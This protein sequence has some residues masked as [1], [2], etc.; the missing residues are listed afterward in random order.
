MMRDIET[1]TRDF[2]R[3]Q[4]LIED[5]DAV[6]VALSGGADSVCLLRV[7]LALRE[8]L[9]LSVFATHYNHRLRGADSLRDEQF[10]RDLC[11]RLGVPLRVSSGDVAGEAVHRRRSVEET[12]REMRYAFLEEAA[13]VMGANKIATGH[14]A[15]DNAETVLLH[16]TR[17]AGLR[18]LAGIPPKRECIV[19]PLLPI[20]RQ[21]ILGYLSD[22]EQDFVEDHTNADTAIRRNGIRYRVMPVLRECN[23]NLMQTILRQSEILRRDALFLDRLA[24]DAFAELQGY[25]RGRTPG[26]PASQFC[27]DLQQCGEN[28]NCGTPRCVSPTWGDDQSS[29]GAHCAPLQGYSVNAG[30]HNVRPRVITESPLD[31]SLSTKALLTLDL[32]ISSRVVVLAIQA[33]GGEAAEVHVEQVLE[34][35]QNPNP[36]ARADLP[37][38]QVRREYDRLVFVSEM[39]V[40][41]SFA[42]QVLPLPGTVLIPEAGLRIKVLSK[43]EEIEGKVPTFLFQSASVC[44]KI[45][46]RSRQVGDS[47]RL[48][49]SNGTKTVKKLM[50]ER[51]I[52]AHLRDTLPVFADDLGVIAVFGI[53]IS[54]RVTPKTGEETLGIFVEE[55]EDDA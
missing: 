47:I 22:L 26:R 13:R 53:G 10:V 19:R 52:P 11:E 23:P 48:H 20:S 35:A 51:K 28:C 31:V 18:G 29:A 49:G 2:I 54:A 30:A 24:M 25:C 34:L 7:L 1:R 6:L 14:H 39:V 3:K 43:S 27:T 15:D 38:C 41:T 44:G 50:I 16:L 9:S 36:S 17:G 32:S 33:A 21:E 55:L 42:P 5:G 12:A 40:S 37:R 4:G 46:V 45:S 8:R